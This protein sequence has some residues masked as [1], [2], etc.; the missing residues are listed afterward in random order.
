MRFYRIGDKV[1][2]REKLFSVIDEVLSDREA[3]STQEEV[4]RTYKVQRTFVSFLETLGEI[5]RGPK[6]ALVGFPIAN[7][8][9]VTE[10][11]E[12]KGLDFLLVFSQKEREDVE[13][14][15]GYEVFNRLLETLATL[16]EFDVVLLLASD[17]RL[18]L[19]ERILGSEIIGIPLGQ[20]PLREDVVVD[21]VELEAVLDDVLSAR[22]GS[23][24]GRIA[25]VLREAADVAERW[26]GSKK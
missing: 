3:G 25:E 9:E 1:V 5:R 23:T 21:L 13:T 7:V 18:E 8:A 2:S 20:T 19:V 17:W 11:A 26:S 16:R 10:L 14:A 15:S 12:R 6:V 22:E 24:R 4:A